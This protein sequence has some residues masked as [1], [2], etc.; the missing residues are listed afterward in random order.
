MGVALRSPLKELLSLLQA[1][2][3]QLSQPV[4][5]VCLLCPF[6]K[7]EPVVEV[8]DQPLCYQQVTTTARD[9]PHDGWTHMGIPWGMGTSDQHWQ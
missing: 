4:S 8:A 3:A 1:E 6:P 7:A 5:T 2:Q 9:L